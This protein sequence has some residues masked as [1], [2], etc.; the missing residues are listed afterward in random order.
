MP[1]VGES[2]LEYLFDTARAI[3]SL[4]YNGSLLRWPDI[5]FIFPHSGAPCRRWPSA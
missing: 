3:A 1:G 4:V 2:A 5:R